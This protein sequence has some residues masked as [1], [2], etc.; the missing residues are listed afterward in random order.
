[1]LTVLGLCFDD[2]TGTSQAIGCKTS[3]HLLGQRLRDER[4]C[5]DAHHWRVEFRFDMR[6]R[7]NRSGVWRAFVET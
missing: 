2:E 7:W 6:L 3:V 4:R 1:M 5:V